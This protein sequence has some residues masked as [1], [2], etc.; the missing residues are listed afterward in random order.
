MALCCVLPHQVA[1]I[2]NMHVAS[3]SLCSLPRPMFA[4]TFRSIKVFS[5]IG[6]NRRVFLS[7][8]SIT[9]TRRAFRIIRH[10]HPASAYPG[11]TKT[12]HTSVS[13]ACCMQQCMPLS[14]LGTP[15][16]VLGTNTH[17][18]WTPHITLSHV[19]YDIGRTD[20]VR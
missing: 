1:N 8:A 14:R 18:G 17:G 4:A 12:T 3:T 5:P 9:C 11:G 16:L 7:G 2:T 13:D 6:T 19:I 10:S 15:L 20:G